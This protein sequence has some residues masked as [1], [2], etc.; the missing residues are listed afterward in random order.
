MPLEYLIKVGTKFL[1]G[2]VA[3]NHGEPSPLMLILC[4]EKQGT[5]KTYF[6]EKF[7]P[8]ELRHLCAMKDLSLLGSDGFKRD[9]EISLSK[10]MLIY[11]DEMSGKSK[12]D[13][14]AIKS[15]LSVTSTTTRAA[16]GR[17]E[18]RRQRIAGFG[19]TT[20]DLDLIPDHGENRRLVPVE[21]LNIDHKRKDAIDPI[22]YFIEAYHLWKSSY[23]YKL[24]GD[25]VEV[26][27]ERTEK[28]KYTAVEDEMLC[29]HFR[30]P[31]RGEK[32]EYLTATDILNTLSNFTKEK[33]LAQKIGKAAKSLGIQQISRR[34]NGM[35]IKVYEVIRL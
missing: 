20:N 19:G 10:Y 27:N 29:Q 23:E 12:R 24:L 5:G 30:K 4:G 16:Y 26:L 2:L 13:H 32:P 3:S 11:D 22:D 6:W 21:V 7:L 34:I 17:T 25:E 1:V 18:E 9:L 33:M 28:Y 8:K 31:E 35:P 14:R 15:I